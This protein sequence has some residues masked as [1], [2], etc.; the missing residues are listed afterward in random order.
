LKPP[1]DDL[2]CAG[3][4][5]ACFFFAAVIVVMVVLSQLIGAF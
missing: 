4:A 3:V 1:D 2:D 5:G